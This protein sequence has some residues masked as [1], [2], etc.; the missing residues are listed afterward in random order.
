MVAVL[1]TDWQIRAMDLDDLD[2]VMAI[3]LACYDYPW[4]RSIFQDCLRAGYRCR[5]LSCHEGDDG[6]MGYGLV[7]EAA[8]EAHLLNVCIHPAARRQGLGELL[9]T[10]L[11]REAMVAGMQRFLLEVRPSNMAGRTLYRKLG[12]RGIGRRPGYYPA[13]Q[14]RED[15]LVLVHDLADLRFQG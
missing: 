11:M 5:V 1:N 15:A 12:F 2:Q 10:H 9:V 6:V 4:R 13:E 14:G 7:S 8:E 3:E